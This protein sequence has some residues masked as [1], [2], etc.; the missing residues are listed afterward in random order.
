MA[1]LINVSKKDRKRAVKLYEKCTGS[2]GAVADLLEVSSRKARD[3]LVEEGVEIRS[4]GRPK[5]S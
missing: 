4:R 1:K 3:I 5:K 2:I